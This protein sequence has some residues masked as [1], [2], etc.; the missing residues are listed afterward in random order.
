MSLPFYPNAKRSISANCPLLNNL[1]PFLHEPV[2]DV[3]VYRYI[4]I[5]VSTSSGVA[6]V[7]PYS[8]KL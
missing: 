2:H 4:S 3:T 1:E 8:A 6:Y 7:P 5:M